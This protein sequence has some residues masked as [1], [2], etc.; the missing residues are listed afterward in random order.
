[1]TLYE[2]RF[3]RTH[4][5]INPELEPE[6]FFERDDQKNKIQKRIE[7]LRHCA[8]GT[9]DEIIVTGKSG[10]GKSHFL[11]YVRVRLFQNL[12]QLPSLIDVHQITSGF[13][14]YTSIL[15]SLSRENEHFLDD[16][17]LDICTHKNPALVNQQT[18]ESRLGWIA[19]LLKFDQRKMKEWL[20]GIEQGT[21]ISPHDPLVAA[22]NL[23][24]LLQ[25]YNLRLNRR[26]P[27]FLFDHIEDIFTSKMSTRDREDILLY[28]RAVID[29]S[30]YI[31]AIDSKYLDQLSRSFGPV[32]SR[33]SPM[34]FD[35]LNTDEL[36]LFFRELQNVV[37][38]PNYLR[39]LDKVELNGEEVHRQ[40]YPLTVQAESY[41]TGFDNMEPGTLLKIL[42][43]AL[44]G[45][46]K[47]G[48]FAVSRSEIEDAIKEFAPRKLI[49]CQ[50]C[51]T[52]LDGTVIVCQT[53]RPLGQIVD[54]C[55]PI[56]RSPISN[57]RNYLVLVLQR[58]MLDTSALAQNAFS[59][60]RNYLKS[61]GWRPTI[62]FPKAVH[63]ELSAW[64]KRSEMRNQ[65]LAAFFECSQLKKLQSRREIDLIDDVGRE[66]NQ[67][68][69]RLAQRYN[70]IDEIII[71]TAQANL[72]ALVTFDELMFHD[73]SRKGVFT[74]LFKAN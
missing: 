50:D 7:I 41:L 18:R 21:P 61:S 71:E 34:K 67:Y 1:M 30:S 5:L 6:T 2:K 52:H 40:S 45:S 46:I 12:D 19:T 49:K 35:D 59:M 74:L 32:L 66:P 54:L 26:Y 20:F 14:F 57:L 28:A 36:K 39:T 9:K 22:S 16:F 62:Y 37:T 17:L 68:E 42:H 69:I 27:I 72:C 73:A 23:S 70:P 38:D 53:G 56:C 64:D 51:K 33:L 63:G 15:D 8:R 24:G 43:S 48:H 55:C 4:L 25:A 11:R 65:M 47:K 3:T 58:L 60:L 44:Q 10:S 13:K 29:R 31:V